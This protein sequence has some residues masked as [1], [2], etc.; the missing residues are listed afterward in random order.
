MQL[1]NV[2]KP[3]RVKGRILA[4]NVVT[5]EIAAK[6]MIRDTQLR[7]AETNKELCIVSAS[8][9]VTRIPAMEMGILP[10]K[11]PKPKMSF[12]TAKAE[13]DPA[14]MFANIERLTK[15]VGKGIQP[16]LVITGSAGTGKT[17]LVKQTLSEMGLEE[18]TD[19][20]HFKGRATA[21]GLFV[22]LYENR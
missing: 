12:M 9:R 11:A 2:F 5:G 3:V 15:M 6:G 22:T 13:I 21:A 7:T 19:F 10:E 18:S 16:S 17:Y 8:G 14:I 4:K 20:V 1:T